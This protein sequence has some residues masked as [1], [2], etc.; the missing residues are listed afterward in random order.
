MTDRET[1]AS[2]IPASHAWGLRV[3]AAVFMLC[4]LASLY[5][6]AIVWS[7]AGPVVLQMPPGV[8]L[9]FGLAGLY[10]PLFLFSAWFCARRSRYAV[11]FYGFL[12]LLWLASN[13]T[14]FWLRGWRFIEPD[15]LPPTLIGMVITVLPWFY[16]SFLRSRSWLR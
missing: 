4:G 15:S 10:G 6:T 7:L 1:A 12:A 13:L 5:Q 16:L 9:S 11:H 8:W 3:L 14:S 2:Q